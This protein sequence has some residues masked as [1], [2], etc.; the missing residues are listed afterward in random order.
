MAFRLF[1]RRARPAAN[2]GSG[3]ALRTLL[4]WHWI[5]SAICLGGMLLFGITG[6]TLN[7]ASQIEAKPVIITKQ[8]PLPAAQLD[9]LQLLAES[10]APPP[11]LPHDTLAWLAGVCQC[12]VADAVPEWSADEVYLPMPRPGGDAWL[13]I[14]L[15]DKLVEHEVTDRGWLAYFNDLHKGRHTGDTWR[16]YIDAIAIGSVVFCVTGLLILQKHAGNRP[17]TWPLFGLGLLLPAL[18]ALLTIH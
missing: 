11:T 10:E 13:R 16:W 18:I 17:S 5:S 14:S 8:Y 4:Q 6:F 7:H 9:R 15:A 3:L 1:S 12:H 2:P